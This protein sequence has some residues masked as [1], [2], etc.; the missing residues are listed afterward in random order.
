MCYRTRR[1]TTVMDFAAAVTDTSVA[2]TARAKTSSSSRVV[3]LV[4]NV[5]VAAGAELLVQMHDEHGEVR[6]KH[7][8]TN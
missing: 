3:N 5:D 1:L 8:W 4:L 6:K 2:G 7:I